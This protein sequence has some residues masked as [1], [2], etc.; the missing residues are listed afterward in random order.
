MLVGINGAVKPCDRNA[1][2]TLRYIITLPQRQRR[3]ARPSAARPRSYLITL[4]AD[5]RVLEDLVVGGLLLLLE[6]VLRVLVL[7]LDRLLHAVRVVLLRV[8]LL[9]VVLLQVV[10]LQVLQVLL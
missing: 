1:G 9:Q 5:L 8:V 6:L 10:L 2:Y 3:G 7:V 4:G